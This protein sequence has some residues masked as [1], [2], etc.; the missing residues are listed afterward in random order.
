MEGDVITLQDIF[1]FD[2]GMGIDEHGRFQGHLKATGVRPKFAEKLADLGIR[3]GPEV[4]QPE[5]FAR[6]GAWCRDDD[7]ARSRAA[8]PLAVAGRSLALLVGV[9]A[10]RVGAGRR[11][12]AS[13]IRAG[14][15]HRP[16]D[17]RRHLRLRRR[18]A[19]TWPTST[20][21]EN[22]DARSTPTP[23]VPLRRPAAR[24][25]S[26]SSIDTSDVDGRRARCSSGPRTRLTQFVDGL[27]RRPT[28]IAHRDASTATVAGR[29]RRSPPTRRVL[30][31]ADRQRRAAERRDRP[32]GRHRRGPPR[33]RPSDPTLQPN[34]VVVT[35][36]SDDTVDG[37]AAAGAAAAA[38]AP[39]APPL[40]AVGVE[41][42][43]FD[44]AGLERPGRARPAAALTVAD[45]ADGVDALFD[46]GRRRRSPAVRRHLRLR[47]PSGGASPTRAHRR[48]RHGHGR[49]SS[50]AARQHGQ[51]PLDPSPTVVGPGVPDGLLH[52][53]PAQ[54]LGVGLDASLAA[55]LGAYALI[56]RSSTKDEP[57]L[58]NVPAALLRGLRRRRPT[59]TTRT[60]AAGPDRADPAGRRDHRGLRRAPGLP[61]QGRGAARAGQPAAAA[62][63]GAVLLRRRGRRASAPARPRAPGSLAR[64]R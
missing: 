46:D 48:R 17:G 58:D 7:R 2:F 43:G 15:R 4:F 55:A 60:A 3:L 19:P 52:E 6:R 59:R 27:G 12:R 14:R 31:A 9:G 56:A 51:P 34:I 44:A 42:P 47:P 24:S 21:R 33:S 5:A 41:T 64:R 23:P 11:R 28:Q 18:R 45:D 35:D 62:G 32:V 29:R 40:F 10:G 38:H 26:C 22:G 8:W 20:V 49:R 54:V 37:H 53:R 36:G 50:P 1:L 57:V 25:A 39:S 30:D 63:R 13:P 61:R 16:G